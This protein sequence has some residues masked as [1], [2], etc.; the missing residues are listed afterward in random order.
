MVTGHATA[1]EAV[2]LLQRRFRAGRP[3]ILFFLAVARQRAV[4]RAG[5]VEAWRPRGETRPHG[6]R[7]E[8]VA[9]LGT[10]DRLVRAAPLGCERTWPGLSIFH[11]LASSPGVVFRA[12][13]GLVGPRPL[14]RQPV[15]EAAEPLSGVATPAAAVV[16]RGQDSPSDPSRPGG[17]GLA[18]RVHP[19][20]ATREERKRMK[21]GKKGKKKGEGKIGKGE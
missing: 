7:L 21:K 6:E 13:R 16:V 1:P 4:E 10:V 14:V 9:G 18:R 8:I 12:G 19:V 11:F 5:R 2:P 20:R 17:R 3:I 15:L